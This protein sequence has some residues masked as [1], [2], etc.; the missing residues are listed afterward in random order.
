M[1]KHVDTKYLVLGTFYQKLQ[2]YEQDYL[3]RLFFGPLEDFLIF[4]QLN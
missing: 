2:L 1:G 3:I 4:W